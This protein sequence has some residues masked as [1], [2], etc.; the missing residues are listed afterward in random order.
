MPNPISANQKQ[1]KKP[2]KLTAYLILPS[3]F[4]LSSFSPHC[5]DINLSLN[6][7]QNY[8][9]FLGSGKGWQAG[10]TNADIL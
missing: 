6:S 5:L 7:A 1:N 9:P 10:L 8:P 3:S 2:L 4:S